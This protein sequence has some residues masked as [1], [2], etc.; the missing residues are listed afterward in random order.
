MV[1]LE[2][3][4]DT[5]RADRY[6]EQ[7]SRH[8]AHQ[9]GGITAQSGD[10]GQLLID[11]GGGTCRMRAE[12]RGLALRVEAPDTERLDAITRKVAARVEQVGRRDGLVVR[13]QPATDSGSAD[14]SGARHE[15]P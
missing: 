13:W 14:A 5:S 4:V 11:V 9:P 8:F 1:S 15:G 12:P 6:V 10:D 3:F 2:A 7:F